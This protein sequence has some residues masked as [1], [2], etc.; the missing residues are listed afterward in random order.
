MSTPAN[1]L[2]GTRVIDLT[3]HVAGPVCTKLLT[4]LGAEV[5]KVERP[6]V[7]DVARRMGPFPGDDA[8]PEKS[9]TFLYLNTGKKSVTLSVGGPTA[10]AILAELLAVSDVLVQSFPAGRL[11]ELG[12]APADVTRENPALVYTSVSHF[13]HSGPYSSYKG[14]DIVGQAAGGLMY[15]VGLPDREPLKIGGNPSLYATGVSA[16]S[17]TVLA[18]YARD[19]GGLGQHVEVS[20]ME[21]T[22]V[23]QIHAS[24]QSQFRGSDG[25]RR[26]SA[27]LRARD[28]W[29]NHGL[30]MGVRG[31]TWKRVTELMGRPELAEDPRFGTTQARSQHEEELDS[32]VGEWVASQPKEK[33]YHT[34]QG[35]STIAGYVATVEDLLRSGQLADRRFFQEVEHPVA[36]KGQYPGPPFEMNGCRPQ[37]GRAPLLGEHNAEVY[38]GLLGYTRQDLVR[39]VSMG[40]G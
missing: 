38:C 21:A 35:M 16:F 34:L 15:T 28:G 40:V 13:G 26:R 29:V 23:S 24:I 19:D 39:L 32:L 3:E 9:A 8:H 6:R 25:G 22:A 1:M 27:L 5:I 30:R 11:D 18:L 31:D 14:S 7:G 20:T 10:G 17:A 36:G 2:E 4:A 37:G 12:L 33:V